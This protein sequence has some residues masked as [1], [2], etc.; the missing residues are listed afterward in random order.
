MA[1]PSRK[2]SADGLG[3]NPVDL[4]LKDQCFLVIN[5]HHT[6]FLCSF[7]FSF[8]SW[9]LNFSETAHH[10]LTWK[11]LRSFAEIIKFRAATLA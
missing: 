2:N 6:V 9:L 3:Q 5:L 1:A 11:V 10:Q 4:H 7:L 8:W